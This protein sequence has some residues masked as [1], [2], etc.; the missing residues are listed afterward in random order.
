M[1][2]STAGTAH[3]ATRAQ[4]AEKRAGVSVA[5]SRMTLW[6]YGIAV[7]C[8]AGAFFPTLIL[9]H[10]FAYP[11]LFLFIAAVMTSAWFGGTGAGLFAV[12]LS[13][14][15]AEYFFVPPFYSFELNT[16]DTSYFIAFVVCSL[17]ASSVSASKK[18]D[19]EALRETRDQLEI[20]VAERTGELQKSNVELSEREHQLRLLTEVIPQQIWSGAPDGSIDYCNQ[21]LLDY[22]GCSMN[23]MKSERFMETIHP[24]DRD[25]FRQSWQTAL[26]TGEPFEGEWRV[27]RADGE[28]RTFVTRAVPLRQAEGK[29]LRWYG[30]NTDIEDHK[31]S[32]QALLTSQ[33]ELAHLSRVLTMGELTASIAH[34]VNQPIAAVVNYGNACLEWLS[35]EPPDLEEARLAAENIIRDGTRAGSVIGQIRALFKKELP[36]KIWFDINEAIQELAVFV[37]S[38]I[39]LHRV[40]I[41]TD[42]AP[43]LPKV[44]ADRVQ[45]QQVVLNLIVNGMDAMGN[46]DVRSRELL[47]RSQMDGS[48]QILIQVE[49]SGEGLPADFETKIFN[50]FYTTKTQGIGM[51]LSI[52]RSIIESHGG[53]LWAQPRPGGGAIFE[54]TIPI[55][56]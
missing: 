44:K 35:A 45:L 47:I 20:R 41:R 26:A 52:S 27:R 49:D 54:F 6:R 50:P 19:A 56:S 12:L 34:E 53:R 8:V 25:L 15:V 16:T 46:T 22:V 37:R 48:S 10:F 14:A 18:R 36:A 31:K 32:E 29:A 38:E 43:D 24:A 17:V 28:Y 1:S 4:T 51:G 42:L 11:F 33:T 23:E 21:R 13:T 9:Q 39:L 7:V 3:L 2:G 30:T 5:M 55:G 40:A